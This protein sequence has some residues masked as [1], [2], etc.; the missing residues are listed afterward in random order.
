M[1][2]PEK[3]VQKIQPFKIAFNNSFDGFIIGFLDGF[4]NI[5][6]HIY[7]ILRGG[8]LINIRFYRERAG[9]K[10]EILAKKLDVQQS[11]ISHWENGR[12]KPS[13]KYIKKM[14]RIFGCT[15]DELMG[16]GDDGLHQE[17]S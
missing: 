3:R 2:V 5:K 6:S 12:N 11:A 17:K 10:Q 8:Y 4:V 15:V 14:T 9:I 16:G 1:T 13:Q 7:E